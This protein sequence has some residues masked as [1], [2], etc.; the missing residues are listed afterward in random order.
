MGFVRVDKARLSR[1]LSL[2]GAVSQ[3]Q[4]KVSDIFSY[5]L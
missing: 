3:S 5:L 4:I 2:N 1:T